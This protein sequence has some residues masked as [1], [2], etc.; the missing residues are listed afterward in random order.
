MY[1]CK[2]NTA[3]RSTLQTAPAAAAELQS[4]AAKHPAAVADPPLTPPQPLRLPAPLQAALPKPQSHRHFVDPLHKKES[5]ARPVSAPYPV[6]LNVSLPAPHTAADAQ[7]PPGSDGGRPHLFVSS[8][9]PADNRNSPCRQPADPAI[10]A[11]KSFPSSWA[12]TKR[13][14]SPVAEFAPFFR[15]HPLLLEN[16]AQPRHFAFV[17]LSRHH[18]ALLHHFVLLHYFASL[19]YFALS[20][21]FPQPQLLRQ[22]LSQAKNFAPTPSEPTK[23]PPR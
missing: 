14:A 22:L 3:A 4:S 8:A 19:H 23:S 16:Y 12:P 11:H 10:P 13:C 21:Y 15:F 7:S 5:P 2:P 6:Y 1:L 18:F 20:H 17:Q 9:P